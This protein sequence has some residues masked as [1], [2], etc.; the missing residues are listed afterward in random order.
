M[1]FVSKFHKQIK[2]IGTMSLSKSELAELC[3]EL[4][5]ALITNQEIDN[6]LISAAL[7]E[8]SEKL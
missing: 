6:G 1:K 3:H 7:Q 4:S 5:I 8:A 2:E